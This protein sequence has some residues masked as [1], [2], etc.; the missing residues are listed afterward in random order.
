M[1][2]DQPIVIP[3]A[4]SAPKCAYKCW[5]NDWFTKEFCFYT[6][7]FWPRKRHS[8]WSRFYLT[9]GDF[10]L[11]AGL[12]TS[13]TIRPLQLIQNAEARLVFN[14]TVFPHYTTPL[15]QEIC[16]KTLKLAFHAVN[17]SGHSC[18]NDM[19]TLYTPACAL[20]SASANR[21]TTS[22]LRGKGSLQKHPCLLSWLQHGRFDGKKIK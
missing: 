13:S 14:L 7:T 6:F 1:L 18:F 21:L 11:L 16:L 5:D 9:P 2:P 8:F 17:G 3:K 20:R 15:L 4:Q 19:V 10:Q 12:S 22:S